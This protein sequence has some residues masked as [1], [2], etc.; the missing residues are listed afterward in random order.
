[1]RKENVAILGA[2]NDPNRYSYMAMVQLQECGHNPLLVNPRLD[3]IDEVK[4]YPHL[5]DIKEVIDTLTVYI[6]PH[7]SNSLAEEIVDKFKNE[8]RELKYI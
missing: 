1:M 8:M 5:N 7:I 2:S 3:S 6:N 4:C